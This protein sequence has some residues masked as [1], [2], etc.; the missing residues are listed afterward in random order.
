MSSLDDVPQEEAK[1]SELP[2]QPP[3]RP[4]PGVLHPNT[5]TD[6]PEEV[7]ISLPHPEL[8]IKEASRE[9]SEKWKVRTATSRKAL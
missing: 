6:L 1:G 4:L 9:P 7:K 5:N 2:R 8:Q 3:A